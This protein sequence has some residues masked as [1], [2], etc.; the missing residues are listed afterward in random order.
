MA[1][2]PPMLQSGDTIGI[3]TLGSPLGASTIDARIETLTS[4]GF[5]VLVGDHVY[6][7]DGI[8]AAPA[9]ERASDF[10]RM[11]ENPNVKMILA[12][13]GG[14]GVKDIL[15]YLDYDVIRRN[16]KIIS[17]YSDITILLNVI[18]QFSDLITFQGLMLIDFTPNTPTYNYEQF[19]IT[20]SSFTNRRQIENPVGIPLTSLVQGNVTGPI[21]GGNLTSFADTLG[22]PYEINT[23]GKILLLEEI[24]ESTEK[25]Y[26][27]LTRLIQ[28]GKFRDCIGIVMGECTN[29]P[30]SYG[31]SYDTL[32][33][34]LLVP[35]GKPL[36]TNLNTAHGTYKTT[37]PIGARINLNTYENTLTVVESVVRA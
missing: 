28:A 27:D 7:Y 6:D 4:M 26:R 19:F 21:V 2:K 16:P 35:L 32:I 5:Q 12:S 13:R 29:C 24:H 15:P 37:I 36:M 31:T 20:T 14:T 22:T 34:S 17:G 18:Y 3:V 30:I 23:N 9:S 10:M 33:N 1:I 8:V 11:I 25:I